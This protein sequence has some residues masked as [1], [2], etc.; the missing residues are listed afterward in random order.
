MQVHIHTIDL[1]QI[2]PIRHI[3]IDPNLIYLRTTDFMTKYNKF[4]P[5]LTIDHSE[6]FMQILCNRNF[7][8]DWWTWP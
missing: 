5:P 7:L 8:H 2:N 1:M 4:S 3:Q 6:F